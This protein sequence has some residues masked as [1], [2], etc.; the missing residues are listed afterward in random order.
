MRKERREW[1]ERGERGESGGKQLFCILSPPRF[2]IQ[3]CA[4]FCGTHTLTLTLTLTRTAPTLVLPLPLD[5]FPYS[6]KYSTRCFLSTTLQVCIANYYSR[7]ALE[8][9]SLRGRGDARVVTLEPWSRSELG[10]RNW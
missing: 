3:H 8:H 9:F 6:P 4:Q 7:L 2:Y 5:D 1:R 10:I